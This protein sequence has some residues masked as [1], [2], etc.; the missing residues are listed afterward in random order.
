MAYNEV[1]P[2][3]AKRNDLQFEIKDIKG[4]NESQ[5]KWPDSLETFVKNCFIQ[6]NNLSEPE[7]VIFQT[8]LNNVL[9]RAEALGTLWTIDWDQQVL[10]IFEKQRKKH[11]NK[12]YDSDDRKRQRIERFNNPKMSPSL[13]PSKPLDKSAPVV[14]VSQNIEKSYYRLTSEPDVNLVRPQEVLQKAV[15]VLLEKLDTKPYSYIKDQFK[16]IRQDMTVQHIKNDFAMYIYETNSRIA[17]DNNDLGEFNQCVSQ[18]EYF[19]EK[20][21][22]RNSHLNQTELEFICYRVLYYLIVENHSEIFKIK[23]NLKD[24]QFINQPEIEKLRFVN[25]SFELQN[26]MLTSNYYRF[27]KTID[28]FKPLKNAYQLITTH[29]MEKQQVRSIA[30]M[31]KSYR[32]LNMDYIRTILK[33]DRHKF[34]EFCDK[35]KLTTFIV[36]DV[37][38]FS[39]ARPTLLTLANTNFKR[40]DIKGQV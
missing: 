4:E 20:K 16:A 37:F 6:S 22:V 7:K 13:L 28:K 26:Y 9:A 17:I 33:F 34:T 23:I 19:F 29:L 1:V 5:K 2:K 30:I 35:Y 15:K 14:G 25:L 18:L 38:D 8:E 3:K 24:R 12:E 40:I 27:F 31:G 32:T 39:K 36:D 11:Q 10:P 21:T